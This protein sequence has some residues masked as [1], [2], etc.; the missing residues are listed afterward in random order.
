MNERPASPPNVY[1]MLRRALLLVVRPLRGRGGR[2]GGVIQAYRGYGSARR[3]YLAGRVMQ[4]PGS[5]K[6]PA[7][8]G[9]GLRRDLY[10]LLRR[11]GRRGLAGVPVVARGPGV[12]GRAETDS[13]GYFQLVLELAQ[14]LTA[15]GWHQVELEVE[16]QPQTRAEP[17]VYVPPA[18]ARCLV[19]S[20]IDD[21]IVHTGVANKLVMLWQLFARGADSRTAFPGIAAFCRALHAGP[22]GDEG[23]PLLYVSRGPWS[24]YEVLDEFFR[25]HQIPVGPVLFLRDWGLRPWW[26]VPRR[27]KG[28]K[29]RLIREMLALYEDLPVV[30]VGDSGQRDPEIYA[31]VVHEHP[32]RVRAVYIRNVSRDPGRVGALERLG[33][34]LAAA[35]SP[36]VLAADTFAMARHAAQLGL[37]SADGLGAVL[38]QAREEG[39]P[40]ASG[41]PAA[42]EE[43]VTPVGKRKLGAE[44]G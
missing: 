1:R 19:I 12:R 21:T 30:L 16:G 26:P 22:G 18:G 7:V 4:Q 40:V 14:P 34:E 3:F 37:I 13:G 38:A 35:G 32:Q 6:P 27:A 28:H 20:D 41:V 8:A 43:H 31:Q 5:R 39:E 25:L 9:R 33:A 11:L 42:V 44:L 17:Q 2:R 29:L 36:L 15:G 10:R 24:I 23:N